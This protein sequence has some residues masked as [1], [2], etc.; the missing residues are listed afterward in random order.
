MKLALLLSALGCAPLLGGCGSSSPVADITS[1]NS[2]TPMTHPVTKTDAEWRQQ[3]TAE[4]Y[5][6][7]RQ[8]GTEP[9]YA[10]QYWNTRDD[11][12]YH[13]AACGEVLFVSDTKFDSGCGW[14]S[15]FQPASTN[16]IAETSDTT[17][18]MVRTEVTCSK[19]GGHLGHVFDDGP[20]PTGLRYC[21]NSASL[22]FEGKKEGKQEGEK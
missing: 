20:N 21:I 14:P 7:L 5:R 13:C 3:F 10:G 22:K 17:H 15:F 4:Q 1:T 11:G 18:G 2:S 6:V 16:V 9:P 19:C 12:S 8:K